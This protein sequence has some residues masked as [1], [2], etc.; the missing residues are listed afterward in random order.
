M[1]VQVREPYVN[2][3]ETTSVGGG[4]D[5]DGADAAEADRAMGLNY[6]G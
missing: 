2:K 5:D 6:I 4:G 3:A 1:A